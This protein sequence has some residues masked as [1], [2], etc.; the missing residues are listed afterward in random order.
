MSS[1]EKFLEEHFKLVIFFIL[2]IAFIVSLLGIVIATNCNLN[3]AEKCMLSKE[4]LMP[5]FYWHYNT[6]RYVASYGEF[7]V[8]VMEDCDAGPAGDIII[9][10]GE[11]DPKD[12]YH[13]PLYYFTAAGIY[14]LINIFN[15][16][17]L[18]ALH[19]SSI[20]II[21]ITNVL[22]LLLSTEISKIYNL[23]KKFIVAS[24]AIFS[25]LPV[26]LF[27]S[28]MI[29]DGVLFYPFLIATIY[30]F[31]KFSNQPSLKYSIF[32]G[33]FIGLSLLS[34]LA[35][36]MSF[37]VVGLFLTFYL[38]QKKYYK[39]KLL[40]MSLIIGT[41]IGIYP[42][43]RNIILYKNPI[44]PFLSDFVIHNTDISRFPFYFGAFWGGIYGGLNILFIPLA[45]ITLAL[46]G[47]TIYGIVK[48][49]QNNKGLNFMILIGLVTL[50]F[51]FQMTCNIFTLLKT[52]S[53]IGTFGHGK[54]LVSLNPIIAIF[55]S[56]VLINLKCFKKI[57][58]PLVFLVSI[59]FAVDFIFAFI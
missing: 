40:S 38:M 35:G 25:F 55:S 51:L 46:T 52:G 56:M 14:K 8:V 34:F 12:M 19:I 57:V 47:L 28:V 7:P 32:L 27:H 21:L 9:D 18:I 59:L 5:D 53:C 16:N 39:S 17:N 37:I 23:R 44:G 48:Y 20:F 6:I 22:F 4:Y 26:H 1:L 29:H 42:I 24:L 49:Y 30:M 36:L 2:A 54:Y 45:L 11:C 13:S 58:L 15:I 31:I 33:I 3:D 43:I 50:F 41:V 10:E